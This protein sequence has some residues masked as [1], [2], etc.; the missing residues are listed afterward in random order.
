MKFNLAKVSLAL[1]SAALVLGCQ[2]MGSGPVGPDGLVPQF[3]KPRSFCKNPTDGCH[4]HDDE[5]PTE[6][7]RYRIRLTGKIF[8]VGSNIE[9]DEEFEGLYDTNHPVGHETVKDIFK[10]D[11]TFFKTKLTC[12]L[13]GEVIMGT[14]GL[15][16]FANPYLFLF[17]E[18]NG[19]EHYILSL[20]DLPDPWPP[21][22]DTPTVT[23]T[24]LNGEWEVTSQGK[25]HR[26]ACTGEG[27]GI[28]WSA[29]VTL[30]TPPAP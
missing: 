17:F 22:V 9:D 29:T 2:D 11:V 19:A 18:H 26:D 8:S 10:M 27:V 28:D 6:V 24:D 5:E 20:S 15:T 4:C 30:L 21:T 1:L 16:P 14:F 13:G 25:N 12:L 23:V 7:P 3:D